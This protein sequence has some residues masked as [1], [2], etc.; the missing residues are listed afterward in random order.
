MGK[1]RDKHYSI[2]VSGQAHKS[3]HCTCL[4]HSHLLPGPIFNR[5]QCSLYLSHG[6]SLFFMAPLKLSSSTFLNTSAWSQMGLKVIISP[7]KYSTLSRIEISKSM[8]EFLFLLLYKNLISSLSPSPFSRMLGKQ[9]S[10]D[11][12]RITGRKERKTK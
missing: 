11:I 6:I 10:G 3:M 5:Y 1:D 9:K 2:M 7:Q 8:F 4:F 12:L